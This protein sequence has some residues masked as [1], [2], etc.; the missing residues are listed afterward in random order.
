MEEETIYTSF[1]EEKQVTNNAIV[2][3]SP[4]ATYYPPQ[5]LDLPPEE[6]EQDE[7]GEDVEPLTQHD[8]DTMPSSWTPNITRCVV[9][10]AIPRQNYYILIA[11]NCLHIR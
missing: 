7:E 1:N 9:K 6:E 3:R 10:P 4:T 11:L 5:T 2:F 8:E